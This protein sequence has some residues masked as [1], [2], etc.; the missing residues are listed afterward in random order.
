MT[1]KVMLGELMLSHDYSASRKALRAAGDGRVQVGTLINELH[2][3]SLLRRQKAL[4]GTLVIK[5]SASKLTKE[6]RWQQPLCESRTIK[7]KRKLNRSRGKWIDV[8]GEHNVRNPGTGY[9][10]KDVVVYLNFSYDMCIKIGKKLGVLHKDESGTYRPLTARG[11][12]LLIQAVRM[13][14]DRWILYDTKV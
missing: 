13:G 7:R 6:R 2:E 3:Q 9:L 11:A 1:T 4:S 5:R 12:R 14:R 10:L 8:P